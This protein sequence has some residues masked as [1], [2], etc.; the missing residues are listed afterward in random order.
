M[1]GHHWEGLSQRVRSCDLLLKNELLQP[2]AESR[3]QKARVEVV[4]R[5]HPTLRVEN[6]DGSKNAES[7]V[8]AY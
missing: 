4:F 6:R 3:F 8:R 1:L 5:G 2:W 7:M